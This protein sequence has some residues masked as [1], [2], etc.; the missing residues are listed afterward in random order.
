MPK[1]ELKK[2]K[3]INSPSKTKKKVTRD[4]LYELEKQMVSFLRTNHGGQLWHW[5]IVTPL[6]DQRWKNMLESNDKFLE[7]LEKKGDKLSVLSLGCGFCMHWPLIQ[8]YGVKKFVGIDLFDLRNVDTG[9]GLLDTAQKLLDRFCPN[10]DTNLFAADVRDI[11]KI[12]PKKL[13]KKYDVVVTATVNYEKLG[14]SGISQELFDSVCDR[15]LKKNGVRV[16]VP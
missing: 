16:Y 6:V 7:K 5:S 4:Q 13:D 2:D 12:L 3:K 15:Y 11:E 10:S 8:E 14:S 1:K 9:H